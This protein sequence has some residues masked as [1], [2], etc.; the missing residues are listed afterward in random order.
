[1]PLVDEKYHFTVNFPHLHYNEIWETCEAISEFVVLTRNCLASRLD[2]IVVQMRK[3]NR[4]KGYWSIQKA[5]NPNQREILL[6]T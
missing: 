4:E 6:V 3:T 5:K 1:M 2:Y